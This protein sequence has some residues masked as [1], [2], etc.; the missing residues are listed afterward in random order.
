VADGLR[1]TLSERTFN[2]ILRYVDGIL[3]V[4]DLQILEAMKLIWQRM[5]II[6]EPSGAVPLAAVLNHI[7]RLEGLERIGLIISGGNVDVQPFFDILANH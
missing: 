6:V 5:K 1:T 4:N 7:D 2:Y 3:T